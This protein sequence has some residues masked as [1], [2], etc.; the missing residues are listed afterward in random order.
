MRWGSILIAIAVLA[1]AYTIGYLNGAR[2]AV[3]GAQLS[4]EDAVLPAASKPQ[5]TLPDDNLP[6]AFAQ[7]LTARD[8]DALVQLLEEANLAGEDAVY[9]DMHLRLLEVARELAEQ[10]AVVEGTELLRTFIDLNPHDEEALFALAALYADAQQFAL[11]LEPIFQ[12]LDFPRTTEL[13]AKAVAKRDEFVRGEAELLAE[14]GLDERIAF[15]QYLT[16]REPTN[17]QHRLSLAAALLEADEF[18]AAESVLAAVG[19]FGVAAQDVVRMQQQLQLAAA[20]LPIERQGEAL[21]AKIQVNGETLRLLVDTGATK[22]AIDASALA[23]LDVQPANRVARLLT[24]GGPIRADVY[25]VSQLRF[26]GLELDNFEVVGLKSV[27]AQT[28][29]LLGMDLLNQV[30]ELS[31][32]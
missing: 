19:G 6:P 18:D 9:A 32:Q 22:T 3:V 21:Y 15:Y 17:D 28:Q 1:C 2:S 16:E 30:G 29:G 13:A 24:A 25:T 11:A 26:G 5:Q 14:Q 10:D 4:A 23:A 20:G 31:I 12:V 7:A 8:W 27:P